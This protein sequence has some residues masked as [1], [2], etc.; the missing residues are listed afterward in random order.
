MKK[1]LLLSALAVTT[2]AE[3]QVTPKVQPEV[4]VS[5]QSYI[6]VNRVQK[7]DQYM[8]RTSWAVEFYSVSGSR[9]SAPQKGINIVKMANGTASKVFVK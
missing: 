2:G 1:L 7:A 8:S 5:G 3:A 6:L 9:L 4:P